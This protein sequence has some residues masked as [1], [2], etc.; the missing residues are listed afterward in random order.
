MDQLRTLADSWK[1]LDVNSK[2]MSVL[3]VLAAIAITVA[4]VA[5]LTKPDL[6]PLNRTITQEQLPDVISSLEA[7]SIP[8]SVTNTGEIS[9]DSASLEATYA[10]LAKGG[11]NQTESSG[12]DLLLNGQNVYTSQIKEDL[13][14]NQVNEEELS[15]LIKRIDGVIDA[16]VKLALSKESQFLRDASPAKASVVITTKNGKRLN[17]KQIDGIVQIVAGGIPNLP[18]ANVTVLDQ[19]GKILSTQDDESSQ[20]G[21]HLE[22]KRSIENEVELKIT[23]LLTPLVG[24]DSFSISVEADIN[25]N[26]VENTTDAPVEPSLV[27]SNFSEIYTDSESFG[28]QGV[29]GAL[30]N[31]PPAQAQFEQTPETASPSQESNFVGTKKTTTNY[32]IGRSITHTVFAG[33]EIEKLNVSILLNESFYETP[34]AAAAAIERITPMITAG[35][36]INN[37]RGD[38]LAITSAPF[39]TPEVVPEP[40]PEFHE[41]A[42]FKMLIDYLKWIFAL[43]L[44]YLL[45][46]R[47]LLKKGESNKPSEDSVEEAPPTKSIDELM[48]EGLFDMAADG[49]NAATFKDALQEEKNAAYSTFENVD[50]VATIF[51]GWLEDVDLLADKDKKDSISPNGHTE[52][53]QSEEE[54][55]AAMME[56]NN[57]SEDQMM[58]AMM[59]ENGVKK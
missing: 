41:T 5:M 13:F 21:T 9:V 6:V 1:G 58:A 53:S 48:A 52:S 14:K 55:M 11:F 31:Q 38:N 24:F 29:A 27:V 12:Y 25:F 7:N 8:Y 37:E 36:G 51:K 35:V 42:W 39:F 49:A 15:K 23:S 28:A 40:E 19:S 2:V 46:W 59:E 17:K 26:R 20:S 18:A 47:P 22:F 50:L 57:M 16:K 10:I 54:M 44:L 32:E 34:E 3:A 56:E 30:S 4:A 33:R 45:I 43:L